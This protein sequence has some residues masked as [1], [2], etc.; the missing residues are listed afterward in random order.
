M[1][2]YEIKSSTAVDRATIPVRLPTGHMGST[3]DAHELF[4]GNADTLF[5][6]AV[7][8]PQAPKAGLDVRRLFGV[9]SQGQQDTYT[10]VDSVVQDASG[11]K[12]SPKAS[13]SPGT[14]VVTMGTCC[15]TS[16]PTAAPSRSRRW[17]RTSAGRSRRGSS[18]TSRSAGPMCVHSTR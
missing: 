12:L 17:V 5:G 4:V 9:A 3:S 10:D 16:L 13:G 7:T 11:I 6:R 18:R 2:N 15:P 14:D 1:P 8:A